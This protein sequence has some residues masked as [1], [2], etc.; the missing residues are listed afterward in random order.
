[1]IYAAVVSNVDETLD[2]VVAID[3]NNVTGLLIC[4]HCGIKIMI[5]IGKS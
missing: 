1:M 4:S 5:T 2:V 3:D